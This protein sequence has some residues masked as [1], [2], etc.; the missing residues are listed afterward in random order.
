MKIHF[1]KLITENFLD[2]RK[3]FNKNN[4]D[5]ANNPYNNITIRSKLWVLA[6][7]FYHF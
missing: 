4:E 1:V 5:R 3:N 2:S 6:F 7:I